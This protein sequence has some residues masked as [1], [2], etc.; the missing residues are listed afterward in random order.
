MV[1]PVAWLPLDY[2]DRLLTQADREL[3]GNVGG[4]AFEVGAYTPA[5]DLPTTHRALLQSATPS[6]A[7]ERIPQIWRI[8]H[9]G[10][11]ARVDTLGTCS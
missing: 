9:T 11:R 3:G 8:Y 4:L 1:L 7:V 10:G 5:R 2:Y 6:T